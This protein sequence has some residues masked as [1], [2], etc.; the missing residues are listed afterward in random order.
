MK[1]FEFLVLL[2][3]VPAV[4]AA[5]SSQSSGPRF[6]RD[7]CF[8][9]V[10][11]WGYEGKIECGHVVVPALRERPERGV[12]RLAV[13]IL[14][15]SQ[16]SGAPP[17]V[18]LHGG[19]GLYGIASRFPVNA[20]RWHLARDRDVVIYDQRGAGLSEPKL[21]PEVAERSRW[22]DAAN[23]ATAR[24]CLASMKAAGIEPSAFTTAANAADAI[25]VRRALGY[26]SW[27]IYGVSYGSRL[28]LE[29]MRRD[30]SGIRA[31][32]LS[33]PL[34]PGPRVRAEHPLSFQRALE[35]VFKACA[36]QATCAAAFP[37]IERDFYALYDALTANPIEVT[38]QNGVS[39]EAIRLDG[40]RFVDE[41]QK[42][43]A[44]ARLVPRIPLLIHQLRHGDR[45]KAARALVS[46]D[47][48]RLNPTLML[49]STYD[50]CGPQLRAEWASVRRQ[51]AA[52]FVPEPDLFAAC[53]LWQERFADASTYAAVRSD[54]P[55]LILTSEFDD[56][57]PP[58][59][60]RVLA[61]TLKRSFVYEFPGLVHGVEITSPCYESILLTFLKNPTREPDSSCIAATTAITFETSNL[62]LRRFVL[63]ITGAGKEHAA[64]GTWEA[65]LPGPD[66]TVRFDLTVDGARLTGTITPSAVGANP[67]PS[68]VPIFDGHVE[69]GRLTFK[70]ISPDGARTITFNGTLS[71]EQLDF[72]REVDVP[73][74]AP[75][76]REGVFGVL[77]PNTF[78]AKRVD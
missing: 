33:G 2:L 22:F 27:D 56:R 20:V 67:R 64:I 65:V 1:L 51:L 9:V 21:C 18:Y 66:S 61:T 76:G 45:A 57:T 30:A 38:P 44:S 6:H 69:A 17:V 59:Y 31:V 72:T 4:T 54:I 68:P 62:D 26:S 37:S 15:A 58:A 5:Q 73:S 24:A 35:R 19:P 28:A 13:V 36:A 39:A 74:G 70:A 3:F 29:L 7:Q 75:P 43:L 49:V 32:A 25:D 60:G 46:A 55:T 11:T 71:A 12:I 41:V 50:V 77:G 14:R 78:T 48:D 34:P 63:H 52:P 8:D 53:G 23:P 16:P 10:A 40:S 47:I 42:Q